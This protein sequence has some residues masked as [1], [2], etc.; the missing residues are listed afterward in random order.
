MTS[1]PRPVAQF[2][3]NFIEIF[4]W[5]PYTKSAK[6]VLLCWTK[7]PP[8]L[9]RV[10]KKHLVCTWTL[11]K[12]Q[13]IRDLNIENGFFS[14]TGQLFHLRPLNFIGMLIFMCGWPILILGSLGQG[15]SDLNIEYGFHSINGKPFPPESWNLICLSWCVDGPYWCWGH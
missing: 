14:I 10:K 9:K 5:W 1:S 2:Q 13:D 7:R 8:E 15:H 12:G 3:S 4:L 11:L 6:I